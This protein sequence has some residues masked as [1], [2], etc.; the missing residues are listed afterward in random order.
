MSE[1]SSIGKSGPEPDAVQPV[2]GAA[3]EEHD[4]EAELDEVCCDGSA[5]N[6]T[7]FCGCL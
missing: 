4:D 2:G 1:S 3:A 6:L 5:S 7:S